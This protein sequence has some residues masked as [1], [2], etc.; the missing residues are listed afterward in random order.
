MQK[1]LNLAF[2]AD[3][4]F[5]LLSGLT[6]FFSFA[7]WID[8]F[9]YFLDCQIL[10]LV[11]FGLTEFFVFFW[12][13][14]FLLFFLFCFLDWLTFLLTFIP[15]Y[16]DRTPVEEELINQLSLSN[17][18]ALISP[19][20]CH[21]LSHPVS[22]GC[23]IPPQRGYLLAVGGD[24]W[25]LRTGSWWLSSTWPENRVVKSLATHHFG[26][27]WARRA[28]GEARSD[29]SAGHDSTLLEFFFF[30]FFFKSK[31]ERWL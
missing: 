16:L 30:F 22:W 29:Q 18:T 7:F 13:D 5:L 12:T 10:F 8:I 9:C 2:W 17:I 14:S 11:F 26:P 4:F 23:R 20:E 24:P 25:C 21:P 1:E 19:P 15:F 6:D 28:V 31:W 27:Y 3:R